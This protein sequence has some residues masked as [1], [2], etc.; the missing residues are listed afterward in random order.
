V[1]L[2]HQS[3]YNPCKERVLQMPNHESCVIGIQSWIKQ[4]LDLRHI[5][6]TVFGKGMVTMH[7]QRKE[8]QHRHQRSREASLSPVLLPF[9]PFR[10]DG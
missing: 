9:K 1:R 10:R 5:E 6:A 2:A 7:K 4:A 8:R 3:S